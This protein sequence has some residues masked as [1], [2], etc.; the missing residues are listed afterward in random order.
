M[1]KKDTHYHQM[2]GGGYYERVSDTEAMSKRQV[3]MT[4]L[5]H[6]GD[7]HAEVDYT[8]TTTGERGKLT[9]LYIPPVVP[10]L[11]RLQTANG[12]TTYSVVG[13]VFLHED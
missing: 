6:K 12:Y 13:R 11:F 10:R 3:M 1:A 8:V 7:D 2:L 5:V 4:F 9:H